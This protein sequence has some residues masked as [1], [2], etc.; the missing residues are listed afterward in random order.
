MLLAILGE[1]F[2][3]RAKAIFY[4]PGLLP[5]AAIIILCWIVVSLILLNSTVKIQGKLKESN[6]RDIV[7]ILLR[8]YKLK[9]LDTT[10]ENIIR[11]VKPYVFMLNGRIISCLFDND[12]IHLNIT[13][14]QNYNHFSP[15]SVIYNYYRC[16]IIAKDFQRLQSSNSNP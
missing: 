1:L 9:N 3:D 2:A 5:I 8:Y 7:T 10:A 13:S 4:F 11:D 6:R 14:I 15:F 12:I 16:K